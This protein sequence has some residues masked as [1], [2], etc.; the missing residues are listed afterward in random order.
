MLGKTNFK[1]VVSSDSNV[2]ATGSWNFAKNITNSPLPTANS[3][4]A[5]KQYVDK[6]K[7]E[8]D[9]KIA[10]IGGGGSNGSPSSLLLE[11]FALS[12]YAPLAA[13]TNGGA[14]IIPGLTIQYTTSARGTYYQNNT[15]KAKIYYISG[16]ELRVGH[17][18]DIKNGQVISY[19]KNYA[20]ALI[21]LSAGGSF[22]VTISPLVKINYLNW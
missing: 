10:G 5:N 3:H 18:L 7:S 9:N 1:E 4:V 20:D 12:N 8:L 14:T 21:Y 19:Y 2:S 22:K 11:I 15:G 13:G 16:T 6:V 17:G